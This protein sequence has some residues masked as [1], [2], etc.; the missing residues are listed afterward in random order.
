MKSDSFW[1]GCFQSSNPTWGVCGNS[2]PVGRRG[3]NWNRPLAAA[4]G[5]QWDG[6][7][8]C[9]S[10]TGST[11][12][13]PEAWAWPCGPLGLL[14]AGGSRYRDKD[15][16]LT[17]N[18]FPQC[19][20]TRTGGQHRTKLWKS[21]EKKLFCTVASLFSLQ[22]FKASSHWTG[23]SSTNVIPLLITDYAFKKKSSNEFYYFV[24][25]I[26]Y[27]VRNELLTTNY[28]RSKRWSD[29]C[30]ALWIELHSSA[31][32]AILTQIDVCFRFTEL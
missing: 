16:A 29:S 6:L 14:K 18:W 9:F 24:S 32:V 26:T 10:Q 30:W 3:G 31:N 15:K 23:R 28:L 12:S 22:R 19:A 8:H 17:F 13:G 25:V 27:S 11:S 20:L 1:K 7:S 2:F 21:H 5:G 4:E